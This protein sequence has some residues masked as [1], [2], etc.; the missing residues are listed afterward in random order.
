MELYRQKPS[1]G[2]PSV[3]LAGLGAIALVLV[4]NVG[5]GKIPVQLPNPLLLTPSTI[6]TAEI[7]VIDSEAKLPRDEVSKQPSEEEAK[8]KV[9]LS[10]DHIWEVQAWLK[11]FS[12][13]PGPIDGIPG[14]KTFAAVKKF[15]SAHQRPETGN[16]NY[17][18]LGALRLESGLPLR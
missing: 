13:D 12:L 4:I 10:R 18:L 14:P 15:E 7:P 1:G 17:V 3:A 9:N 5:A 11:A 8:P 16:I 2:A 6:N